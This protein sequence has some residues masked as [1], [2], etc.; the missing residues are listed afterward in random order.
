MEI[1]AYPP[2]SETLGEVRDDHKARYGSAARHT[3]LLLFKN[4]FENELELKQLFHVQ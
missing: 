3:I 1:R 2:K 4:G